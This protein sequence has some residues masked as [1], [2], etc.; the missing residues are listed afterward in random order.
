MS[1][2]YNMKTPQLKKLIKLIVEE[3]QSE[4]NQMLTPKK[5]VG[6]TTEQRKQ[7]KKQVIDCLLEMVTKK[8]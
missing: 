5:E 4:L 8:R 3:T 6:L 1:Y 7:I 2:L